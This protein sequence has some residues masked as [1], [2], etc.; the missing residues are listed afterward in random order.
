MDRIGKE[1]AKR[2]YAVGAIDQAVESVKNNAKMAA[3]YYR[4]LIDEGMQPDQALT[5]AQDWHSI[6]WTAHFKHHYATLGK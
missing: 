2:F 3:G 4:A 5:L 1:E 6:F